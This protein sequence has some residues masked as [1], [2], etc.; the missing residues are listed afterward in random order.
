MAKLVRT[1]KEFLVLRR[2]AAI[3]NSDDRARVDPAVLPVVV[4]VALWQSVLMGVVGGALVAAGVTGWFSVRAAQDELL[5]SGRRV[6]GVVTEVEDARPDRDPTGIDVRFTLRGEERV[7]TVEFGVDRRPYEVG[8]WVMVIVDENDPTRVR[9]FHDRNISERGEVVVIF[10]VVLGTVLLVGG[11][12]TIPRWARRLRTSE[13]RRGQVIVGDW[14]LDVEFDDDPGT[15]SRFVM[16]QPS[17]GGDG[18]KASWD[19][20]RVW[21]GRAGGVWTAVSEN[22]LRIAAVTPVPH[23]QGEPT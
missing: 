15:V 10:G 14:T 17:L 23:F 4:R 6:D 22:R 13:W 9:T 12:R 19:Y 16:K 21:I 18:V 7:A 20:G 8:D 3:F 11:L 5:E 1:F 2:D